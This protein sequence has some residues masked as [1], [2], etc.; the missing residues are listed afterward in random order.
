[1][2]ALIFALA[3]L[4]QDAPQVT[5]APAQPAAPADVGPRGAPREDYPLVAWCYGALRGYL[6]MHDEVMPEVKR[7]ETTYRAP[8]SNLAEDLKV[9]A[10]QQ[11]QARKDLAKFQEAMTAAEKASMRPINAQGAEAL[12]R[13]RMVWSSGPEITK[14]RKAQEWMSW[15]LPATC[16][17][18]ADRLLQRSALMSPL[19]KANSEAPA[20]D[21]PAAPAPEAAP[22]PAAEPEAPIAEDAEA[23]PAAEPQA[24]AAAEDTPWMRRVKKRQ[25]AARSGG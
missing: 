20:A 11:A 3:L 5:A 13:G 23:A 4:A 19:L 15:S 25:E 1:M 6:E 7:I 17:A 2:S 21:A 18:A 24:G 16:P 12:R 8:G 22:P 14:A 9:Y 10:D